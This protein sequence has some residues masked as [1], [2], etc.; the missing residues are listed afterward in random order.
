MVVQLVINAMLAMA[1]VLGLA[2]VG[3]VVLV[4]VEEPEL[5]GRD[6]QSGAPESVV[7]AGAT[8]AEKES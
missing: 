8:A 2:L 1:L 7:A 6:A 4:L 5:Q 3:A